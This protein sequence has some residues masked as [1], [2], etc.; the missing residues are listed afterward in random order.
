MSW[1]IRYVIKRHKERGSTSNDLRSGRPKKLSLRM[2]RHIT[3]EASKNPFVS[4][5]TLAN[6]AASTSAVQICARNVL[7]DAHI[8]RRSPRKK[9]LITE[10]N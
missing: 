3:R 6:D 1:P 5:I 2:K 9:S 10:R 8:Y 7:H 4:A